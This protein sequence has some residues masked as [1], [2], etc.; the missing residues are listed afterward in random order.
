VSWDLVISATAVIDPAVG[1]VAE[2]YIDPNRLRRMDPL[3]A[4]AVAAARLATRA[5][6]L[7]LASDRVA[8]EVGVSFGTAYGCQ[9]TALRYAQRLVAHGAYF[10]NPIDFPD[11]I[12]GAP[13]AHMA[14][15]LKLGGPSV[16]H[17]DGHV[18]GEMALVHAALAVHGGRAKCMVVGGGEAPSPLAQRLTENCPL[19]ER[20][21][22]AA[23]L[24]LESSRAARERGAPVLARLRGI[25]F[26]S[27]PETRFGRL[28]ATAAGSSAALRDA[29]AQAGLEP[30][31]VDRIAGTAVDGGSSGIADLALDRIPAL[32]RG[33][34]RVVVHHAT[35]PGGQTVALVLTNR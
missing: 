25:G 17:V 30:E 10:T 2:Q 23:C 11:S 19:P 20:S 34:V 14:M 29:L 8:P 31:A 27:D 24:V 3:S 6:R 16:T 21:A 35:A 4:F 26:G 12:D 1:F 7:G 28:P 18:A 15:E 33:D 13:A 5:A 22:G 32:V 9:A